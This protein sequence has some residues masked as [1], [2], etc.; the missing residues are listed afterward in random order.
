VTVLV[1][2]IEDALIDPGLGE[3]MGWHGG[4]HCGFDDRL[5]GHGYDLSGC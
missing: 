1:V 2:E 3:R 4:A 5:V